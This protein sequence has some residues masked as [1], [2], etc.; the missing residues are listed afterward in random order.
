MDFCTPTRKQ[1][2]ELDAELGLHELAVEDALGPH[3][4]PKLD[5]YARHLFL[6]CHA[7]HLD[8][9]RGCF[10]ETEID[11]FLN[12]RWLITVREGRRVP[13]RACAPALGPLARPRYPRDELLAL[14]PARRRRRRLLRHH[15]SL[16]RLLR[17]GQRQ[18]LLRAPPQPRR[19]A[20]L[21]RHAPRQGPLPPPRR[22][23]A[24]SGQQPHAARARRRVRGA[25]HR[26]RCDGRVGAPRSE[27][28]RRRLNP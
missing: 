23:P 12:Q 8:A 21:V 14:R 15:P 24:R 5:H 4:R 11:A 1:L 16:R 20:A 25:V 26:D 7:V 17:R 18:H 13:D 22:P 6:S 3:Q 27:R 10:V 9:A 19:A 28:T 2:A